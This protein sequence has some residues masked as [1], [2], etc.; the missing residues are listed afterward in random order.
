M[1]GVV[2]GGGSALWR[3]AM[4]LREKA[5]ERGGEIVADAL[6]VPLMTLLKNAGSRIEKLPKD[7][8][9]ESDTGFNA[10]QLSATNLETDG[11]LDPTAIAI[12]TL[13]IAFSHARRV[14]QTGAWD[15][16]SKRSTVSF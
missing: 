12:R 9:R 8:D 6:R 7:W 2:L 1:N 5:S 4:S 14:L 11:V 16:S 10:L 13:Q 3:A 15:I